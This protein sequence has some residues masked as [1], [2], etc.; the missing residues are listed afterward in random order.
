VASALSA[1]LLDA[2][3]D[4]ERRDAELADESVRIEELSDRVDA[5]WR[6]AAELDEVLA[7]TPGELALADRALTEQ[8]ARRARA[9][10]E[11]ESAAAE[12]ARLEHKVRATVEEKSR[13]LRE[14]G[15]AQEAV[16]DTEASLDR[17]RAVRAALIDR[18][19][20]ARAELGILAAEGEEIARHLAVVSRVSMSGRTRPEHDLG[21]LAA[22][23]S[24]VHAALVVV[25]AQLATER[26][27][28]VR[29][30][31][32]LGSVVLGESLSGRGVASVA[33]CVREFAG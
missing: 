5:V 15:R 26:D 12:V 7:R 27:R 33:R 13:A 22:W 21:G 24:R 31:N 4:L 32:E 23:A 8:E 10:V 17:M 30:A 18:E 14:L 11:L 16:A 2:I 20:A 9:N 3:G 19:T 25:R 28:L 1:T 6:R 29:E